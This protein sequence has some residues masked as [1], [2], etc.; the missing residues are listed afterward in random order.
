MCNEANYIQY[1]GRVYL[2]KHLAYVKIVESML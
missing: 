2:L 1:F